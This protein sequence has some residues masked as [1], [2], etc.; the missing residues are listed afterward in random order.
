M[1]ASPAQCREI[2]PKPSP[3]RSTRRPLAK[4]SLSYQPIPRCWQCAENWSVVAIRHPT[5]REKMPDFEQAPASDAEQEGKPR[6]QLTLGHL[7]PDQL[8]LYGDR[9]NILV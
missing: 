3:R 7:Y 4:R 2:F 8:N 5:G 9:G 6:Y 1:P